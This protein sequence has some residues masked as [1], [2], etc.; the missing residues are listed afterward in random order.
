MITRPLERAQFKG[1]EDIDSVKAGS[2]T[3]KIEEKKKRR[4]KE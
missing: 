4:Q 3:E 2:K 1:M